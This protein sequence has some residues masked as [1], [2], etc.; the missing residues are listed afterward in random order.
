LKSSTA[1]RS[2][3]PANT[4]TSA[5]IEAKCAAPCLRRRKNLDGTEEICVVDLDRRAERPA[6]PEEIE[7]GIE[8]RNYDDYMKGKAA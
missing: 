4:G 8:Y 5:A 3:P 2:G 7:T 1:L 6:T